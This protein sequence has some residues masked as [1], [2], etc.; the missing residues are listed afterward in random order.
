MTISTELMQMFVYLNGIYA[1]RN[2]GFS[3]VIDN[4][5]I[6][7]SSSLAVHEQLLRFLHD[8]SAKNAMIYENEIVLLRDLGNITDNEIKK[9]LTSTIEWDILVISPYH[10]DDLN[11]VSEYSIVKKASSTVFDPA[12][13][14]IASEQFMQKVKN[15]DIANTNIYVYTNPFLDSI[16]HANIS[17]KYIVGKVVGITELASDEAHYEW[18]EIALP[19]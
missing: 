16:T 10:V 11:D 7:A 12:Y 2:S 3:P 14:Y 15:Y 19:L 5:A 1:I 8:T 17:N 9:F 6:V 18:Q 13:V 4:R